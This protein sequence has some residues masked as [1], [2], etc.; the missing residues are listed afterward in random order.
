MDDLSKCEVSDNYEK[1]L[2]LSR[3]ERVASTRM[4]PM[5]SGNIQI[6]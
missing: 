2:S 4:M 3:H 6:R 1:L 5:T